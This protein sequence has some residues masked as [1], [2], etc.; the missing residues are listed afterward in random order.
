MANVGDSRA[1]L[2][3][4]V[5]NNLQNNI[6]KLTSS[7]SLDLGIVQKSKIICEPMSIDHKPSLPNEHERIL[8]FGGRVEPF[9]D[10][11]GR[12]KGPARVWHHDFDMPGLAMSRSMGDGCGAQVGVSSIPEIKEIEI[13]S[14]EDW[15]LIIGSDGIWEFITNEEAAE[16]VMPY[17]SQKYD[18]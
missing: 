11:A 1:V 9:K 14:D 7:N 6:G 12:P 5:N 18:L 2:V 8:S 10:Q 13:N 3:K 15:F 4:Q 17:Y 16:L